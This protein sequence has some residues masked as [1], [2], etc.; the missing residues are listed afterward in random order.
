VAEAQRVPLA[1]RDDGVQ[2]VEL[3]H[4][5]A[6]GAHGRRA[7]EQGGPLVGLVHHPE[8]AVH[9][10][11]GGD[12][13]PAVPGHRVEPVGAEQVEPRAAVRAGEL[14]DGAAPRECA[15]GHQLGDGVG[16]LRGEGSGLGADH[17]LRHVGVVG[18]LGETAPRAEPHA[19]REQLVGTG[20]AHLR[21]QLR[22]RLRTEI[23]HD[24]ALGAMA[25]AAGGADGRH[26][27]PGS[28]TA[29]SGVRGVQR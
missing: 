15:R 17:L 25:G 12:V 13:G 20:V 27:S 24:L 23:Q 28:F 16:P 5:P 21:E 7:L 3:H 8:A 14:R 2:R 29:R 11:I 6:A 26:R 22:G 9:H 18:E 4:Q 1:A 19:Q 10:Q